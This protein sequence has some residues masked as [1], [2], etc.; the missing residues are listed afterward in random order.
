VKPDPLPWFAMGDVFAL[1]SREDPYPLVGLECAALAKPIVTYRNGGLPELLEAAGPEAALGVVDH[2][3]VGAMAEQVIALL[4]NDRLR[5]TAGEQ[6]RRH[7]LAHH[8]ASVAAPA[9]W[10]DLQQVAD[11]PPRPR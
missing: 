1:T 6:L 7:V 2:L 5:R 8:D 4:D 3:D 9:L 11:G 10:A